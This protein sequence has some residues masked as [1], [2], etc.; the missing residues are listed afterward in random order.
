MPKAQGETIDW[1]PFVQSI[2][3]IA[4]TGISYAKDIYDKER[5]QEILDIVS[6]KYANITGAESAKVKAALFN[7]IGYAT[8][9]IC[10]RGLCI[11]DNKILLVKE[12]EEGLWSLPGGWADVNLSPTESLLKEIKEE[13][14]YNANVLRMLAF[15][16]KRMHEHPPHWP[17]TY[18]AF[19]HFEVVSGSRTTSYEISE[20]EYFDLAELPDLSTHR[21][22]QA[23]IQTLISIIKNNLP[24]ACD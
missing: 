8:P 12:R 24:T 13:T 20:I 19:Y 9:K 2:Q 22:T 3:A 6:K 15:W 10:V 4:Q 17:H 5:Y 7:E 14:G 11:K 18:L 16:D 21:V 1:L 23:Q